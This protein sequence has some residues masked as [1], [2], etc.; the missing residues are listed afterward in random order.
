VKICTTCGTRYPEDIEMCPNDGTPLFASFNQDNAEEPIPD[1]THD[2]Q[3]APPSA[4]SAP[5]LPSSAE[6]VMQATSGAIPRMERA[7]A[8]TPTPQPDPEPAP[9]LPLMRED[10]PPD[11]EDYPSIEPLSAPP[12]AQSMDYPSVEPLSDD[13]PLMGGVP[14]NPDAP[15]PVPQ[16]APD[17]GS[18]L[19]M[20][21]SSL[22]EQDALNDGED[23][24]SLGGLS[25]P[26]RPAHA[27]ASPP[28]RINDDAPSKGGLPIVAI[29]VGAL[30]LLV[31]LAAVAW[32]V[33]LPMLNSGQ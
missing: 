17:S 8:R 7:P 2:A 10:D 25:S 31:A 6:L 21:G 20:I 24:I 23:P 13:M 28:A 14:V 12:A 15:T 9:A 4:P 32:F 1:T 27:T 30:V 22:N 26:D 18:L 16:R 29:A 5:A 3:E 19:D 33:V 11:E